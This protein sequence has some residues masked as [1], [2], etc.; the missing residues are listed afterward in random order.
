MGSGVALLATALAATPAGGAAPSVEARLVSF[1]AAISQGQE[2]RLEVTVGGKPVE[3]VSV[4]PRSAAIDGAFDHV[5]LYVDAPLAT[6]RGLIAAASALGDR[7]AEL[8][9]LGAVEL[10]VADPEP[11]VRG[12]TGADDDQLAE[13]LVRAARE[14]R[15]VGELDWGRRR[16]AE[17]A[18]RGSVDPALAR[19]A[20][21][22]EID[23]LIRQRSRLVDWLSTRGPGVLVLV[24]DGFDL[25]PASFFEPGSAAGKARDPQRRR[26]QAAIAAEIVAAGW[27]VLPLALGEERLALA[28]DPHEP[29]AELAAVSGGRLIRTRKEL[30][31][32]LEEIA[33]RRLVT[34]ALPADA[35]GL[36]EVSVRSRVGR[37]EIVAPR[38]ISTERLVAPQLAPSPPHLPGLTGS[39]ETTLRLLPAEPD[40]DGELELA[41]LA[42]PAVDHVLFVARG[43]QLGVDRRPPYSMRFTLP[44]SDEAVTLEAFGYARDGSLLGSDRRIVD[45]GGAL[46]ALEI[47]D[48]A[49]SKDVTG[50][51]AA[52]T[53]R[54]EISPAAERRIER[55]DLYWGDRLAR[56]LDRA[57]GDPELRRAIEIERPPGS[58]GEFVRAVVHLGAD[59][60]LEATR[61]LAPGSGI[62]VR[63]VELVT[64]VED[65]RRRPLSGLASAD[66]SVSG[67]GRSLAVRPFATATEVPLRLGVALDSSGS[68]SDWLEPVRRG[69][70]EF[71][72]RTLGPED[73]AFLVDFDDRPRLLADAT[74]D[75][76]HL[77]HRLDVVRA[78]GDTALYDAI[79]FSL[80]QFDG[81]VGRRALVLLSDGASYRSQFGSTRCAESARSLAVPIYLVNLGPR[82]DRHSNP[83]A[84]SHERIAK[85]SG[86][87]VLYVA[88]PD[89]LGAALKAIED[90]LA[91]QYLLAVSANDEAIGVAELEVEIARPG[92]RA[93]TL[94]AQDQVH[95]ASR[96]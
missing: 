83:R 89:G 44:A 67:A 20:M 28:S 92:A 52:A 87:Q 16:F 35:E 76:E 82:P 53:V 23:L 14:S 91:A 61:L 19:A 32:A 31:R 37:D 36:L 65:E 22:R 63:L 73:E 70:R 66:F 51:H 80:L 72:D 68:M 48:L 3:T 64:I 29:L 56:T 11:I 94:L 58:R 24:Q 34:V 8:R 4:S 9:R 25:D 18:A 57:A 95:R 96:Q 40:D 77:S 43:E 45:R 10:V 93:R 85:A 5:V 81:T 30:R 6:S 49:L 60:T 33:S 54:L 38:W 55:L 1:P 59:A 7:L 62:D 27:T 88:S 39:D 17:D 71:F 86:G 42:A 78:D 12:P 75:L 13:A 50:R 79:L 90:Q 2:E 15:T 84:L 41:V 47:S 74:T 46:L 26:E 69:V 21:G